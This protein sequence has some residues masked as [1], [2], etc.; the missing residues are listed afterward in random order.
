MNTSAFSEMLEAIRS[1]LL[2]I[3]KLQLRH[4][5]LAEDVVSE[6]II[7]AFEKQQTFA[8]KS[9]LKTWVV[10]ILKHKIIDS[11]RKM[12]AQNKL[13]ISHEDNEDI[14]DYLFLKDG[15]FT[16]LPAEW[17][18]PEHVFDESRFFDVLELCMTALPPAQGS[19]FLM[20][21]WFEF[22]SDEISDCLKLTVSN[23]NVMLHR[24]RLRLRDCLQIKWFGERV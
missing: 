19:V 20:K 23:V 11:F 15:H 14:E 4:D 8:G 16:H 18:R 5:D 12:R 22:S 6:T 7:A 3:A 10:G 24:A 13:F 9:Q 1:D 21:E 17:G 2:R